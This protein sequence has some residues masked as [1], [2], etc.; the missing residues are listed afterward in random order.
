MRGIYGPRLKEVI[1]YGSYSRRDAASGSDID[2]LIL[3]DDMI[4][5]VIEHEKYFDAIW[6]L[7]LKYDTVISVIALKQ[8]EYRTKTS[9]FILNAKREGVAI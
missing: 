4:E 2:V 6:E 8:E 5:P 7:G 3:L 1:L 9:P